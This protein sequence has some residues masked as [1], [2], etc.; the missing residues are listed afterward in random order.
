M[1]I[2]INKINN[3]YKNRHHEKHKKPKRREEFLYPEKTSNYKN[4]MDILMEFE[5]LEETK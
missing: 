2:Q 4:V 3:S 5:P 1:K